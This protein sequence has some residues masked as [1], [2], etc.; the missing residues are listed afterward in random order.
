MRRF[1]SPAGILL[2]ALLIS[3]GGGGGDEVPASLAQLTAVGVQGNGGDE[4]PASLAQL[5][6][7]GVQTFTPV[8]SFDIPTPPAQA[9]LA[10]YGEEIDFN[11]PGGSVR[12]NG[13]D[14]RVSTEGNNHCGAYPEL[15]EAF[16]LPAVVFVREDPVLRGYYS[17]A[18]EA[19]QDDWVW[20][21]YYRGDWQL[22]QGS[23][24]AIL[25][26]IHS[27]RPDV[28][29]AYHAHGCE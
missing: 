14:D 19:R 6:P 27:G 2:A 4:V 23:E 11:H 18:L 25:Y 3:C 29:F 9:T 22:W 16:R 7:V 5:T 20:T 28:A 12:W 26:V 17:P 1:L 8:L 13:P 24:P 15:K 10:A 21:G